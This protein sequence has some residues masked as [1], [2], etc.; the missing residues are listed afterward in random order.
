MR[1]TFTLLLAACFAFAANA[2]Q[3][4]LT[5]VFDGP[6]PGGQPKGVELYVLET[7]PDLSAWGLGSANNGQGSD[8][9]EYTFPADSVAAGTY[10]WVT[11]DAAAFESFFGFPPTYV[12]SMGAVA[13]NGDDAIELFHDGEVVDVFG[14][15][16]TDGSG[17]PWEYLDSWAYRVDG[18]G[19]DGETFV[20]GNWIFGGPNLFDGT[21]TNSE[22][23]NPMPI[24]TWM[25]V[26]VQ[27]I[28]AKDDDATVEQGQS[29]TVP[30]LDND[31]LPN[32]WSS[33]Q[34]PGAPALGSATAN[35][36]G[37]V[38]Y[39]APPDQCDLTDVFSYVVCDSL[40]CDTAV[41]SV[42]VT[43]PL[44]Y[45]AYDIATVTTE[46]AQGVAD[47]LGVL[48][49][50]TGVVH[51][52]NMRPQGLQFFLLD[53]TGGIM[54]FEFDNPFGYVVQE[55]DE[56]M[57]KG[58]IDQY[59]GMTQLRPH[60]LTLFSQNNPL[61]PVADVPMLGEDTE[62]RL[63]RRMNVSLVD[64]AQW[65][66]DGSSFNV[67]ITDG[68]V[69]DTIRIDNDSELADMPAPQ[70]VFHVTGLGGQ[71]APS[72]SPPFTSGYQLFP[73]YAADIEPV[74]AVP[75]VAADHGIRIWPVPAEEVLFVRSEQ[76]IRSLRVFDAMGRAQAVGLD[77][78]KGEIR[79]A[80]L[81]AGVYTVLIERENGIFAGRFVKQ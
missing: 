55:G 11:L 74:T 52:I 64:P 3:L 12:D 43:C 61:Q 38:T 14:D 7:V 10:L 81:P 67:A 26:G 76:P 77:L 71:Y 25:P 42:E 37:T 73:R 35:A 66:G 32:G 9:Q 46:D 18:T 44:Q 57:I 65:L 5:G 28:D 50:L 72:S 78:P 48:C 80:H 54:V 15:I 31:F 33:L 2:Q 58:E 56:L 23:A 30:V 51:G 47:S 45:P 22:A 8:G 16:H 62:G 63:V 36:D 19:P 27:M 59:R 21:A 49:T 1:Q 40:S 13:V 34:V 69:V 68:T 29:V 70:G 17:Q 6:L 75:E 20:L 24:G 79:I 53:N 39:V 60:E 41:V 4:V